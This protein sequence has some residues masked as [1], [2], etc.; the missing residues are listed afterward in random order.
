MD[1]G[2]VLRCRFR[3]RISQ[4]M[5]FSRAHQF[6]IRD[7]GRYFIKPFR[8]H[9]GGRGHRSLEVDGTVAGT[10]G[11]AAAK[12]GAPAGNSGAAFGT[13]QCQSTVEA[14]DPPQWPHS[15]AFAAAGARGRKL[16]RLIAARLGS[17]RIH[18]VLRRDWS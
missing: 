17:G 7:R 15:P 1:R 13:N 2:G 3:D 14:V 12:N 5:E 18:E 10:V 8:L 9:V 11:A 16:N 6:A 4:G